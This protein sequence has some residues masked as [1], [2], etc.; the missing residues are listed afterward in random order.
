MTAWRSDFE[1]ETGTRYRRVQRQVSSSGALLQLQL[2]CPGSQP[3]A[4]QRRAGWRTRRP[5]RRG[6]PPG[7]PAATR[8]TCTSY[9]RA[10]R[11][12]AG[13]PVTV[14][15]NTTH[16]GHT[17]DGPAPARTKEPMPETTRRFLEGEWAAR[18]LRLRLTVAD[19][20]E[21]SRLLVNKLN[22]M[23]VATFAYHIHF[24]LFGRDDYF[25][26]F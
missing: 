9:V 22:F 21:I 24:Q 10:T 18:L 23:L 15:V 8:V 26:V 2:V 7:P 20:P 12:E 13:G 1:S 19:D 6:R 3:A 11:A 16:Y 4:S 25:D 14:T 5:G 17:L